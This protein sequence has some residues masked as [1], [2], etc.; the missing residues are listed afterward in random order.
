MHRLFDLVAIS[1]A[2]TSQAERQLDIA[3]HQRYTPRVQGAQVRIFDQ[4][5][6]VRL[7]RLVNRLHSHR[8]PALVSSKLSRNLAHYPLHTTTRHQ[9]LRRL[10]V[11]LYLA[12]RHSAGSIAVLSRYAPRRSRAMVPTLRPLDT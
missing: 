6:R 3:R 11:V 10:L 9:K 2:L 8:H 1:S 5:H 12:Q 4:V 7:S